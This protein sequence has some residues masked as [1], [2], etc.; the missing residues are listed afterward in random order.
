[1][2]ESRPR[3]KYAHLLEDND[4]R[5]W[6]ENTGRGS[7]A[8]A[9][10]AL[11]NLGNFC[12]TNNV[13]PRQ[14]A[15]KTVPEIEDFLMD[16][17]SAAEKKHAGS[18]IHNTIK[19]IKSWLAHNGIQLK[20]KIRITGAH[21]TPTLRNERTPTTDELKR[22]FLSG[23]KQAR[24]ACALIAQGGLRLETL[25]YYTGSDGLVIGDLPEL[26]VKENEVSFDNIPAMIKIRWNL[27][28]TRLPYFTFL[29][30]EG[31]GYVRDYLEE[32]FR[33][34][35][36]LTPE[37]AVITPKLAQKPFIRTVNIGAPILV[38]VFLSR[39]CA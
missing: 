34:G 12:A 6:Y 9:D 24:A 15:T 16:Y 11:R 26:K 31:C 22:I 19:I 14:L 35:E 32:R 1:M 17:V 37:S 28:K 33:G 8:A 39:S 38:Y 2:S 29:T 20:R 13:T 21:E 4:V 27:S 10:I 18:Y 30:E 5:R 23:S 36:K 7:A 3:S 25:G